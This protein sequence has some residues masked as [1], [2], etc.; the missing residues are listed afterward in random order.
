MFRVMF[1][2][3]IVVMNIMVEKNSVPP[4][5]KAGPKLAVDGA[6][7]TGTSSQCE[8]NRGVPSSKSDGICSIFI[9]Q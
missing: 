4:V 7:E 3:S 9:F 8:P 1:T 5:S 6:P 2:N